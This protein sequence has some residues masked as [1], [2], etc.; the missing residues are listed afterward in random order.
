MIMIKMLMD[1]GQND[2]ELRLKQRLIM[3]EKSIEQD[4]CLK[5]ETLSLLKLLQ[6]RYIFLIT[7][8]IQLNLKTMKSRL[9]LNWRD[10]QKKVTDFLGILNKKDYFYQE[11]MIQ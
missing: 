7:S 5:S 11:L 2:N 9:K 8:N 10:T 1:L 6:E 4:Q 3:Q